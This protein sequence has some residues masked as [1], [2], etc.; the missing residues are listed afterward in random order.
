MC[1]PVLM[2]FFAKGL[3]LP[4]LSFAEDSAKFR[5]LLL[6]SVHNN[7]SRTRCSSKTDSDNTRHTGS[8]NTATYASIRASYK[9]RGDLLRLPILFFWIG[10]SSRISSM[11]VAHHFRNRPGGP[12]FPRQSI[13]SGKVPP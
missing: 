9:A 12:T 7:S 1:L 13:Q 10:K 2:E 6:D 8:P 3:S 5:V 4:F 11:L